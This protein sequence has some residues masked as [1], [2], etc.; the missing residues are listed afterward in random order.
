MCA[1]KLVSRVLFCWLVLSL[2][3]LARV[4]T[5]VC[6]WVGASVRARHYAWVCMCVWCVCVR[7]R[8]RVHVCVC[9]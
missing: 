1:H 5:L 4:C 8:V 7:D 2:F 9:V 6:V 3:V